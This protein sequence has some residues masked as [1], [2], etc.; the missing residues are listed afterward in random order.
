MGTVPLSSITILKE[1][2]V[3]KAYRF[4]SMV[5]CHYFC[6]VC[7]VYTHNVRRADPTQC[8]YN[9]GC[10]VGV[11]PTVLE[12]VPVSDGVNHPLD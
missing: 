7:G 10:L 6:S 5:A 12:H 4:N 8:G 9:I 11:D 2:S 1:A 3:L